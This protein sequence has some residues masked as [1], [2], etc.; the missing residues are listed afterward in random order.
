MN[1]EE[2]KQKIITYPQGST[3][4]YTLIGPDGLN[5]IEYLLRK[6]KDENI[7]GDF[8]ETGAWKG[9]ACIFARGIMNELGIKGKVYVCDSYKGLPV[10]D[11]E[12]YPVD[13]GDDH[14]SIDDLR[15]SKKDVEDNFKKFNLLENV[16][17]VEGWF[18][19]TLPELKKEIKNISILRLDGD[20]YQ[21]TMEA[22][23]NLYPLVSVGGYIIIDDYLLWRAKR[24]LDDF[25][26]KYDI[27]STIEYVDKTYFWKKER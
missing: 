6:V 11:V 26:K 27:T 15:I 7:K 3:N 10:P 12:C 19:D 24:A 8:V 16:I 4:G 23:E 13:R 9:G 17:F 21:S 5:N 14:H 1:I 25:M 18:K 20:M 22:L 2:F